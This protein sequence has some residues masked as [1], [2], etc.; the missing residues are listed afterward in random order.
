MEVLLLCRREGAGDLDIDPVS[1]L[2]MTTIRGIWRGEK[3]CSDVPTIEN[4]AWP[5]V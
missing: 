5:V 4:E 3:Y 1:I 2:T